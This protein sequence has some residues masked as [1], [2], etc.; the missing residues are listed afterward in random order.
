LSVEY[1]F[2]GFIPFLIIRL[3]WHDSALSLLRAADIERDNR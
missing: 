1:N 2:H 3:K